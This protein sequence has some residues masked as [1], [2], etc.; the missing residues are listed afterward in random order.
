L[1]F[2]RIQNLIIEGYFHHENM[3]EFNITKASKKSKLEVL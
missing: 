3:K 2:E 1:P